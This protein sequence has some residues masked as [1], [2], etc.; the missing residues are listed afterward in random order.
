MLFRPW[1][2]SCLEEGKAPASVVNLRSLPLP[3]SLAFVIDFEL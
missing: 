1:V 3:L 2:G